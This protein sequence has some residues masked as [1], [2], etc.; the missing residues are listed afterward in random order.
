MVS[1]GGGGEGRE[2]K[3]ER[4]ETSIKMK[5]RTESFL[6]MNIKVNVV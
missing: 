2:K 4:H 3:G 1:W 6:K 5:I